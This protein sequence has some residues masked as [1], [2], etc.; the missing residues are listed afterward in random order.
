VQDTCSQ[1]EIVMREPINLRRQLVH[2]LS[3]IFEYDL[4]RRKMIWQSETMANVSD[5]VAVVVSVTGDG[6]V[7]FSSSDVRYDL[8][9]RL[10]HAHWHHIFHRD[11]IS[12][13]HTDRGRPVFFR[14]FVISWLNCQIE[15]QKHQ[16][17]DPH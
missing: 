12:N 4:E 6:H 9:S 2:R 17:T 7:T 15:R 16:V 1:D 5:Q 8:D 10:D 14:Y 3:R 11:W 13:D